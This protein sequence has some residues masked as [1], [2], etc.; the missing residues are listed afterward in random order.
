VRLNC[1]SDNPNALKL[2]FIAT[3]GAAEMVGEEHPVFHSHAAELHS[4]LAFELHSSSDAPELE[5]GIKQLTLDAA[6]AHCQQGCH[7]RV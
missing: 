6:G 7:S 4:N 5:N 3:A 1:C 2:Y